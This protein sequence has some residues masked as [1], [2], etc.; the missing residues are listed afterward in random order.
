MRK[1]QI[2]KILLGAFLAIIMM[3]NLG[4]ATLPSITK[5]MAK[6]VYIKALDEPSPKDSC[7][8]CVPVNSEGQVSYG[9]QKG[10]EFVLGGGID[11]LITCVFLIDAL[12]IG[13]AM[14]LCI[15]K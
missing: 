10:V 12:L 4:L 1:T 15:F 14:A 9:F 2:R 8:N 13:V 11:H 5:G 6:K 7:V 3:L